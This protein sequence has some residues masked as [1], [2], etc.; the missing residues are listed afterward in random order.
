MQRYSALIDILQYLRR[1]QKFCCHDPTMDARWVRVEDKNHELVLVRMLSAGEGYLCQLTTIDHLWEEHCELSMIRR[2]ASSLGL[3]YDLNDPQQV[4]RFKLTL[5]ARLPSLH[6]DAWVEDQIVARLTDKLPGVEETWGLK[7]KRRPSSAAS[8]VRQS[9]FLHILDAVATMGKAIES[10]QEL[11]RQ[12]DFH[13]RNMK[14][15]IS[16]AAD[17][18]PYRYIEAYTATPEHEL[19]PNLHPA[20]SIEN[21]LELVSKYTK[22][23]NLLHSSQHEEKE[24]LISLPKKHYLP[25]KRRF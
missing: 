14:D 20:S 21:A 12:K 16:R 6:I 7:L 19:P 9:L 3:P 1:H 10:Q 2:H 23:G 18:I 17:Y 25:K 24:R 13:I 4:N 11:I 15:A 22:D 8:K 5:A